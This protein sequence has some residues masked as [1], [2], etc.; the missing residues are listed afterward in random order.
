MKKSRAVQ[1]K[2]IIKKSRYLH[3]TVHMGQCVQTVPFLVG[4]N[5]ILANKN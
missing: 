1:R 4:K 5:S 3:F 2:K